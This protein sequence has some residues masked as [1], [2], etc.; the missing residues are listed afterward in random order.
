[1]R[2]CR[3]QEQSPQEGARGGQSHD[4]EGSSPTGTKP[5]RDAGCR[6][7]R[8]DGLGWG[9][10]GFSQRQSRPRF[11]VAGHLLARGLH[12]PQIC[13]WLLLKTRAGNFCS[14]ETTYDRFLGAGGKRY[15]FVKIIPQLKISDVVSSG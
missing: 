11:T 1:M 15:S 5:K 6:A 14:Q 9:R 12:Q 4:V 7:S 3:G 2:G 8:I 13:E 10:G